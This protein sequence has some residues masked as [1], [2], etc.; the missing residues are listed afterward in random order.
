MAFRHLAI[1]RPGKK[2]SNPAQGHAE[3]AYM[4][5]NASNAILHAINQVGRTPY[6]ISMSN[7]DAGD[8][9]RHFHW[10]KDLCIKYKDV[11][12][13]KNS[14]NVLIDVDYYVD[15]HELLLE[16]RPCA[17]YT[18][19]PS[20]PGDVRNDYSYTFITPTEVKF[21]PSN[22]ES[23]KHQL[24]DWSK[25]TIHVSDGLR[26]VVYDVRRVRVEVNHQI[27]M[28]EP[29][30]EGPSFLV[31]HLKGEELARFGLELEEG[32]SVV[33][34]EIAGK[35]EV[36]YALGAIG[37]YAHVTI[38]AKDFGLI[39][40]NT[41]E[42]VTVQRILSQVK[43]MSKEE[44]QLV[45]SL[46]AK[47]N[48]ERPLI[49]RITI[50]PM[51]E[52]RTQPIET[53]K[54]MMH[55]LGNPIAY[56]AYAPESS[57]SNQERSRNE[58]IDKL[59]HAVELTDERVKFLEEAPLKLYGDSRLHPVS[60]EEV[61]ERQN[62]PSQRSIL[63]QAEKLDNCSGP[64]KG[65]LKAEAYSADKDPRSIGTVHPDH[66]YE[67]SQF[68]YAMQA[69]LKTHGWYGFK[70]PIE[71]A[72]RMGHIIGASK[73]LSD[74]DAHRYDGQQNN[75]SFEHETRDYYVAFPEEYHD[76]LREIIPRNVNARGIY[77]PV[78]DEQIVRAEQGFTRSSG[79]PNT[80]NGNT[81]N[82]AKALIASC[83][84]EGLSLE[85][86]I[87]YIEDR[88]LIAGDD[89]FIGDV[90]EESIRKGFEMMGFERGLKVNMYDYTSSSMK[91]LARH[92]DLSGLGKGQHIPQSMCDL[93]RQ[94]P[95]FFMTTTKLTDEQRKIRLIEK[96]MSFNLTDGNTPIIGPLCKK[97]L[98]L[99]NGI[100]SEPSWTTWWGQYS[101]DEQFPNLNTAH[102]MD[103]VIAEE[104][105]EFNIKA[106]TDWLESC[107]SLEQI[108]ACPHPF[109]E[110]S[111]NKHVS[112]V[113]ESPS[114]HTGQEKLWT[115]LHWVTSLVGFD[116]LVYLGAGGPDDE[117]NIK[118]MRHLPSVSMTL[119]DPAYKKFPRKYA[120][121]VNVISAAAYPKNLVSL[122][123]KDIAG[124]KWIFL[125]DMLITGQ[126]SQPRWARTWKVHNE[127]IQ[128]LV[129]SS[130]PPALMSVKCCT[131]DESDGKV[132][133]LPQMCQQERRATW[134]LKN[135]EYVASKVTEIVCTPQ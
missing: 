63:D 47:L 38:P 60:I 114:D 30:Y 41:C 88:A 102:W 46:L 54:P 22:A 96:A 109:D 95:K 94:L 23:Y 10:M 29:T 57:T 130:N 110:P 108:M 55:P 21:T 99:G 25:D 122:I 71:V 91:Y 135:G 131:T 69:E 92:W 75:Y 9:N 105:P 43:E 6:N 56:P 67:W 12:K 5:Q 33:A 127:M 16:G 129:V 7:R 34:M 50:P 121:N 44:G 118:L 80:S 81:A 37:A 77:T 101:V 115:W 74:I 93:K 117:A 40:M 124:K 3:S 35:G 15:M 78:L 103:D 32:N 2:T 113:N 73:I 106:F 26:T 51:Y 89:M 70:K 31:N 120:E 98:E 123:Q 125:S 11:P 19:V 126:D 53:H 86:A 42:N 13:S 116:H 20:A 48:K 97:I 104:Y 119:I 79:N 68:T 111:Q 28:L 36:T 65:F 45:A 84:N 82:G 64:Q 62:R 24:W 90:P 14:Y 59:K 128:R 83:I 66:K 58:R 76:K 61:R 133:I 17:L 8:G 4:R 49:S 18:F 87:A 134:A 52:Y 107:T 72:E 132:W 112:V 39:R 85:K 27:V 100:V 1:D